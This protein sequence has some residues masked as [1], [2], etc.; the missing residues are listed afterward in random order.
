VIEN[1]VDYGKNGQLNTLN[2]Y[3]LY[4]HETNTVPILT[5]EPGQEV[6][7][8]IITYGGNFDNAN[9]LIE[10]LIIEK[11]VIP[12]IILV[13]QIDPIQPDVLRIINDCQHI[14]FVEE[15]ITGGTIGDY[16]ISYI[17]QNSKFQHTFRNFS[18]TRTSIP[19]VK[20]LE[21]QILGKI[22]LDLL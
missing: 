21:K 6:S 4:Y 19:S 22:E 11:D 14:Y 5:L 16:Y 2:G 8:C 17:A 18:S 7:A 15:G 9:E 3:K 20:S 13:S 1:K 10:Q 12:K